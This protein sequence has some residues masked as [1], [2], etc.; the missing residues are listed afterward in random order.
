[1]GAT[2]RLSLFGTVGLH[3]D[4]E[5]FTAFE[6]KR[7]AKL[8]V[9]LGLSRTGKMRR[10]EVADLLWPEDFIDST[11][12]RLRQ[13][14]SRL[15]KGLGGNDELIETTTDF[16]ALDRAS[17]E[18]DL[19]FLDEPTTRSV[20]ELIAILKN[21]FLP[22]WDDAWV[23]AKREEVDQLRVRAAIASATSQLEQSAPN[24]AL[25]VLQA[26]KEIAPKNDLI[27]D[28]I[29]KAHSAMGSLSDALGEY[30]RFQAEPATIEPETDNAPKAIESTHH[31]LALELPQPPHPIDQFFGRIQICQE[32][33]EIIQ[34]RSS[35]RLISLVGTGGIGKT[36][37]AIEALKGASLNQGFISFVECPTESSP[38]AYLLQSLF[39]GN[40]T[41]DPLDATRRLLQGQNCMLVLDNLEHLSEPGAF[42]ASLLASVS[43]LRLIVT[44][45]RPMRVAGELVF[46]ISPLDKTSEA[47]P[48][49]VDLTRSRRTVPQDAALY[50]EIVDLCG[51]IPLTLRLAAAR[52]RLLEPNELIQELKES[53]TPFRANLPDL[54]ERHRDLNRML[55]VAISSL[56][57]E[58]SKTLL[59]ISCFP[60]GITRA[61]A[62]KMIGKDV[63]SVLERLLDSALVWLDDD[64]SPLRFRLLEPIR[65][66]VQQEF[67][68]DLLREA[69]RNFMA[70]MSAV[71]EPFRSTWDV[72]SD[73][74]IPLYRREYENLRHA[75]HLAIE[76][77]PEI[78]RRLYEM[79]WQFELSL[80]RIKELD[81][82]SAALA[83]LPSKEASLIA[84]I[85]LCE[86]WC[87][88]TEGK[89]D[90]AAN[91]AR[92]SKELFDLVNDSANS[93]V[94]MATVNE[95]ERH[96][97][98]WN[99]VKKTYSEIVDV[100]TK[101]APKFLPI[102]RVWRGAVLCYRKEWDAA[103]EDLEYGYHIS[104]E[105][106]GL[107]IQITAGLS[108][109]TIDYAAN[110]FDQVRERVAELRPLVD[111]LDDLGYWSVFLRTE[112]RVAL[113]DNNFADAE[114]Y[115]RQGLKVIS[116]TGNQ[117]HEVEIKVSLARSLI[118]QSRLAE[119]EQ[120][121]REM[122]PAITH[123]LNRVAVMAVACKA[124]IRWKQGK[125]GE[126]KDLLAFALAFQDSNRV[127][128]P[129]ME[130][131]YVDQLR[132]MMDLT[133]LGRLTSVDELFAILSE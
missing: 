110:R 31:S 7:A 60:G 104:K 103:A 82:F 34:D 65:Q 74:Q 15:R 53:T 12:L 21:P 76:I 49:L 116:F 102:L 62:W 38:E 98:D 45:H 121:V 20:N 117:L 128:I 107:G 29:M 66:F 52:L 90:E 129:I 84:Q 48:M 19:E 61:V 26:A 92:E 93:C 105:V 80:G 73:S 25:E 35:V 130:A 44:S 43:D 54:Q 94:A 87:R 14:L 22:G 10:D 6:T 55:R 32:L 115:V 111:T 56:S 85:R 83:A 5:S 36:R 122:A 42:V 113:M 109:L 124:E 71:A 114:Q 33:R 132:N 30:R 72:S 119:A 75:L 68:Q 69:N 123:R 133:S 120:V 50:E 97:Q 79:V 2:W 9:L 106:G 96:K 118:G 100:A 37:L 57:N 125:S 95:N 4:R 13:E 81:E 63:D 86:S 64:V 18:N 39:R 59:Q 46:N 91:L 108:L 24:L 11:R 126:A 17:V 3:S 99:Q 101:S 77:D 67:G 127:D 23:T 41:P 78:A 88:A 89:L 112:A 16:V 8:L 70:Q 47:T 28:L 58:D 27:R 131:S 51:G 40:N 1:M